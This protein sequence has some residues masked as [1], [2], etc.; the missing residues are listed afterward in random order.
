MYYNI[1]M[2]NEMSKESFAWLAENDKI[3]N[4]YK[5]ACKDLEKIQKRFDELPKGREKWDVGDH[6]IAMLK[7]INSLY[8]SLD[9]QYIKM[10]EFVGAY[11]GYEK[12]MI[13]K[14]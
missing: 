13:V 5:Q 8:C 3:W 4:E 12:S 6:L 11:E 7:R 1:L 9:P 2:P 10:V 14:K